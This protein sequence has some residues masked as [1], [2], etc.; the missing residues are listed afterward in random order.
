MHGAEENRSN[1]FEWSPESSKIMRDVQN[2]SRR[3]IPVLPRPQLCNPDHDLT[4]DEGGNF[5]HFNMTS[6]L[7]AVVEKNL[8]KK[9]FIATVLSHVESFLARACEE[10]ADP[11]DTFVSVSDIIGE[12]ARQCDNAQN[13]C[14]LDFLAAIQ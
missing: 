6:N 10:D 12:A 13:G 3:H 8:K 4:D 9:A 11:L 5:A 1:A 2:P 7:M 14:D